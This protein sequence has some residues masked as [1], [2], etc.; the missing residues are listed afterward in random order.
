[1]LV[2]GYNVINNWIELSE[3]KEQD[4]SH[5]RDQLVADL[6]EFQA[7]CGMR[8]IVVYDARFVK[9]GGGEP[10]VHPWCCNTDSHNRAGAR[11]ANM[12]KVF[13]NRAKIDRTDYLSRF[14]AEKTCGDF[15]CVGTAA[16]TATICCLTYG[17]IL[18][19]IGDVL[20]TSQS[21]SL[22]SVNPLPKNNLAL[23]HIH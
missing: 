1:M 19:I 13:D 17:C 11:V 14:L 16:T 18:Y 4:I 10:G 5:A 7:L 6:A 8:V 9:G 21:G 12:H 20:R 3:L 23:Y 15:F 22:L 2:D